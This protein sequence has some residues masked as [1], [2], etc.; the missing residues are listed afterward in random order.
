M[1]NKNLVVEQL[2]LINELLTILGLDLEDLL[3]YPVVV[4]DNI[5]TFTYCTIESV[6]LLDVCTMTQVAGRSLLSISHFTS[7]ESIKHVIDQFI[8]LGG[9]ETSNVEPEVHCL[10]ISD[11]LYI[12][13]TDQQLIESVSICELATQIETITEDVVF[14]APIGFAEHLNRL[15]VLQGYSPSFAASS[16]ATTLLITAYKDL[17]TRSSP[18]E[19]PKTPKPDYEYWFTAKSPQGTTCKYSSDSLPEL[20]QYLNSLEKQDY[21]ITYTNW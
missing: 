12:R 20:T 7:N 17:A 15:R 18:N 5:Y 2:T 8:S 19:E 3:S 4:D 14:T 11:K 9:E 10:P 1:S 6:F 16:F 13:F 21:I